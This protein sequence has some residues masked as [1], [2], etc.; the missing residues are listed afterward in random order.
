MIPIK[1]AS[2]YQSLEWDS[3][4]ERQIM[5]IYSRNSFFFLEKNKSEIETKN[6]M[7][8]WMQHENCE[9]LETFRVLSFNQ[10]N[11]REN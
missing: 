3:I 6:V 11:S 2:L 10:K 1:D 5:S 7:V 9:N 4:H 8:V